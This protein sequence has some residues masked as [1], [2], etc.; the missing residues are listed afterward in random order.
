[1]NARVEHARLVELADA[2]AFGPTDVQIVDALVEAFDLTAAAAIKRLIRMDFAAV[3][4][5]VMP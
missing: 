1:V 4:L 5:E 3:R 2:G